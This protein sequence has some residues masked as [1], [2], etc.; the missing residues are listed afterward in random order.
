MKKLLLLMLLTPFT[1]ANENK[2]VPLTNYI[3]GLGDNIGDAEM[4]YVTYRCAGLYGMMYGIV[5]NAQQEGA[6]EIL[7]DLN[8]SNLTVIQM[9][10]FIYNNL[11]PLEDREFE[12]NLKRSVLPIADN[13][14]K[15]ANASWINSGN[16]FNDYI[17]DDAGIC[18]M[19]VE[20][21]NK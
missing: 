12:E 8:D 13:Y 4:L 9:S 17:M 2:M 20:S 16:Y 3:D 7:A 21:F 10:Q 11:T 14:Q 1:Y 5:E 15:E 18:K 6:K 19:M